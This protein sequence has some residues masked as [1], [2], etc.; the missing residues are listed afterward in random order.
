MEVSHFPL[1][2]ILV[3]DLVKHVLESAI[4]SVVSWCKQSLVLV[5]LDEVITLDEV[6][7]KTLLILFLSFLVTI[8]IL[9]KRS[10]HEEVGL[11]T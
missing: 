9:Q 2:L 7:K 11:R 8:L 1:L 10:T 6:V 3:A 4:H 5:D